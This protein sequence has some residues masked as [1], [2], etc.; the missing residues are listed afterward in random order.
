MT[1][2]QHGYIPGEVFKLTKFSK[3][4]EEGRGGVERLKGGAGGNAVNV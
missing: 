4:V 1:A 2:F 3:T